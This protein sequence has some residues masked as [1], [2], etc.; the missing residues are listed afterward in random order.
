MA[1]DR[2]RGRRRSV[3]VPEATEC[4]DPIL[5]I[6]LQKTLGLKPD[7]L[8]AR[9][10]AGA[11]AKNRFF[12]LFSDRSLGK[13]VEEFLVPETWFFRHRESFVFLDRYLREYRQRGERFPPRILSLP[14]ATGEE[15]YSIAVS[16]FN[17]GLSPREFR[18]DAVDIGRT[19]LQKAHD[20]FYGKNSFREGLTV[21]ERQYF[22][23]EGDG[24]RV[25]DRLRSA[26]RFRWGNLLGEWGKRAYDLIFCRHL[27]IYFDTAARERAIAN[28]HRLLKDDGVLVVGAPETGVLKSPDWK[29]LDPRRGY[30]YRKGS[31]D[32]SVL[33]KKESAG[34]APGSRPDELAIAR[35]RADRGELA[36]AREICARYLRKYPT[37]APG[38]LLL[39][40]IDLAAGAPIAAEKRFR[41]A[42]YLDP[43]CSEALIHLALLEERK[44]DRES[45]IAI[46]RRL[47]GAIDF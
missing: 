30:V 46:R 36:I 43:R 21:R 44:G 25:G 8:T 6:H 5:A 22:Q 33:E 20:G 10:L 41:E 13:F 15:A 35:E 45:S 32:R 47:R 17:A 31:P 29:I 28:L 18:L 12:P 23:P 11:L 7:T 37:R 14:C 16:L 38:Y 39:G 1:T 40:E 19:S 34:P 9:E 26:V 27:L 4:Q 42:L 2:Y 24:Y 3:P